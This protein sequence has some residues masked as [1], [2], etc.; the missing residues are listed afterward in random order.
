MVSA[1]VH[2]LGR[3][4]SALNSQNADS[5]ALHTI[6][7]ASATSFLH[8]DHDELPR[9]GYNLTHGI[10]MEPSRNPNRNPAHT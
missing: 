6:V 3:C 10:H 1:L 8:A 9:K 5:D 4:F 2:R 7:T